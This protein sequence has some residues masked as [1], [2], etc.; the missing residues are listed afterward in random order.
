VKDTKI[1]FKN[2]EVVKPYIKDNY[3]QSLFKGSFKPAFP[4]GKNVPDY[5]K[6]ANSDPS[7]SILGHSSI[8]LHL[9]NKCI[10]IDPVFSKHLG[11]FKNI[12]PKRFVG[13]TIEIA[14]FPIIDYVLITHSH[15]DHLDIKTLKQLDFKVKQYIVPL[16]IKEILVKHHFLDNKIMELNWN[17][18]YKTND[19]D[20]IC[21]PANHNS[22]RGLFDK[23]KTLWCSYLI[24]NHKYTIYHSGD[25]CFAN[26][27]KQI[28]EQYQHID[29]VFMECGQYGSIFHNIHMFP[30][31]SVEAC[32]IL[33]GTIS[34][35]IHNRAYCIS[36]HSYNEPIL[37]FVKKAKQKGINYFIPSL[38]TIYKI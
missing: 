31:E 37:R 22:R 33:D 32:K 27:F 23:N 4:I 28:K 7:Y 25:T 12:G 1:S 13:P 16:G 26:H 14:N 11:P 29:L 35:P 21:L 24:K 20:I 17:Q 10:L 38:Y 18:A 36:F 5:S 9:D 8:F 19:I 30:E 15:F 2:L 34:I 6:V 3:H